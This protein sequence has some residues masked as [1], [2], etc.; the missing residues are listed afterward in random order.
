MISALPRVHDSGA[1]LPISMAG[2]F[3]E[4]TG[5]E[6]GLVKQLT[7][8]DFVGA[9]QL[10]GQLGLRGP[11]CRPGGSF[12]LRGEGPVP[13]RVFAPRP[14]ELE[15]RDRDGTPSAL[16]CCV[17]DGIA[18]Q[19]GGYSR[20]RAYR[21]SQ[22]GESNRTRWF[23]GPP[24][25]SSPRLGRNGLSG[26]PPRQGGCRSSTHRRRPQSAAGRAVLLS[27][28]QAKKA[29]ITGWSRRPTEEKVGGQVGR[30][31]RRSGPGRRRARSRRGRAGS[32]SRRRCADSIGFAGGERYREEDERGERAGDRH[33]AQ[34]GLAAVAQAFHGE[35]VAGRRTW[36]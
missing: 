1:I 13:A 29:A 5:R 18:G 30:G 7:Q 10:R 19:I 11:H 20:G 15:A 8:P 31:R 27:S 16:F 23:S 34:R 28:T 26:A 24:K 22:L 6:R 12:E 4:L 3:R 9:A 2:G 36:R 33:Q 17:V 21:R 14:V 35:D 32:A 25:E